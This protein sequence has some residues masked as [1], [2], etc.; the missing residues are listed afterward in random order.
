MIR[1]SSGYSIDE[2][3]NDP[4]ANITNIVD[5]ML[6]LAVG[7]LLFAIMSQGII[8]LDS[9]QMETP[10][11]SQ[12][13]QE[14][15]DVNQGQKINK[16]DFEKLNSSGSGFSKVSQVYEDPQTGQLFMITD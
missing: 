4:M 11:D 16:N 12:S 13:M 3:D 2:E 1:K 14:S 9:S 5:I 10:S 6:V 8:S 15:I 7:F